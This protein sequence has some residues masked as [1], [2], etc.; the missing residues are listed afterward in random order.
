MVVNRITCF[1]TLL[2]MMMLVQV[3]SA[4]AQQDD[5]A[6][7]TESLPEDTSTSALVVQ[8][9][10][11]GV[12]DVNARAGGERPTIQNRF[13]SKKRLLVVQ[14]LLMTHVRDDFYN[15]WG[16]GADLSYYFTER[17]GLELRAVFLRTTL[18]AAAFDIKERFG[19]VPDA[20]PQNRWLNVGVRYSPGYGKFLMWDNFV[21]HF[22]PQLVLHA[23]VASA[24]RRLLPGATA[25]FSL[26]THWRWGIKAK[27]DL[28]ISVQGEQRERGWVLTTG[29]APVLGVGWGRNF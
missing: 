19:I 27:V 14:P 1:M 11:V 7:G 17:W 24:D 4:Y 8:K 2:S 18:D 9:P 22:D 12:P 6:E 29:F 15:S 21:V 10:D 5:V 3:S 26:M 16:G 20:R 23:G 13:A 25:A 28:G